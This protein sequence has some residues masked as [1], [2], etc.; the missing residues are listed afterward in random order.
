M[1]WGGATGHQ[2]IHRESV[3]K[4]QVFWVQT[5]TEKIHPEIWRFFSHSKITENLNVLGK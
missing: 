2:H 4:N 1:K 3:Q 5:G